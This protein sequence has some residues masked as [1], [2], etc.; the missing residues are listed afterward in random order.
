MQ[1]TLYFCCNLSIV[2]SPEL[3]SSGVVNL[4]QN[5]SDTA[6]L[7]IRFTNYDSFTGGTQNFTIDV[8]YFYT[9]T[10][11]RHILAHACMHTRG[12]I[13]RMISWAP[14]I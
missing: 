3:Q 12:V 11:L 5:S 9:L 2:V 1:V 4:Q 6:Q 10:C 14:N 8:C 13:I 7:I